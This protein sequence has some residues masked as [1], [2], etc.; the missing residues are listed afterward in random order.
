MNGATSP[1]PNQEGLATAMS[2]PPIA[3]GDVAPLALAIA[4]EA[5]AHPAV[6]RLDGGPFERTTTYLPGRRL[7]GV[8]VDEEAGRAE[9]GVVL[10]LDR[11]LPEVVAELRQRVAE[12]TGG[13]PVDVTV[14]DLAEP[15]ADEGSGPAG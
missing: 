8:R 3:T 4:A 15:G 9:I 5:Q 14:A 1:R 11:P 10:R 6:V 13:M 12:L 2:T 7:V